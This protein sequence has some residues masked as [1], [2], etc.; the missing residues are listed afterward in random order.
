MMSGPMRPAAH[1]VPV[2]RPIDTEARRGGPYCSTATQPLD[3]D[4]SE[5]CRHRPTL[6]FTTVRFASTEEGNT[7]MQDEQWEKLAMIVEVAD[8]VWG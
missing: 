6:P 7:L 4:G 1:S 5:I 2:G 8:E 3:R